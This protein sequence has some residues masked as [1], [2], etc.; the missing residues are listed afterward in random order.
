MATKYEEILIPHIDNFVAL[1]PQAYKITKESVLRLEGT[2]L[3]L[4]NFDLGYESP[5]LFIHQT[6]LITPLPQFVKDRAAFLSK[7]MII[8]SEYRYKTSSKIAAESIRIA[9]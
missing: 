8:S 3:N 7:S 9:K 1:A 2:L 6:D 5:L 4:L